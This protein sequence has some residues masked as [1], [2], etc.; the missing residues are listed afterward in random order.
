MILLAVLRLYVLYTTP[1][2]QQ[3]AVAPGWRGER[4]I[5]A[6]AALALT[7]AVVPLM[8]LSAR[9]SL[10][11]F[12]TDAD[13]PPYEVCS[14]IL[15]FLAWALT[16]T[17]LFWE[18]KRMAVKGAWLLRFA[19]LYVM[20]GQLAKLRFVLILQQDFQARAPTATF[21]PPSPFPSISIVRKFAWNA[22]GLFSHVLLGLLT[23]FFFPNLL[24]KS[25]LRQAYSP[26]PLSLLPLRPL[27]TSLLPVSSPFLHPQVLLGLLALLFFPNLLP[28][29]HPSPGLSSSSALAA[30]EAEAAPLLPPAAAA[31]AGAAGSGGGAGYV[32]L[33]AGPVGGAEGEAAEEE[34]DNQGQCSILIGPISPVSPF[35]LPPRSDVWV[36]DA[37]HG[38]GVPAPVGGQ[39]C[40]SAC[41]GR[42]RGAP[43]RGCC[44][45]CT[46]ALAAGEGRGCVGGMGGM[47][48]REGWEGETDWREER[49]GRYGR[50]GEKSVI[51]L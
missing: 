15:A 10:S 20:V 47:G 25:T 2:A 45:P 21:H 11:S 40:L 26:L 37:S 7:C 48:G 27:C 49:D 9:V 41:G 12:S 50:G 14:L 36:D 31:A 51:G 30:A 33:A 6:A 17:A 16:A 22:S 8:Q 3:R 29:E 34:G 1:R 28:Q 38:Y 42:R 46:P 23:L 13:L 5:V 35:P 32:P 43:S 39:R 24:L 44:V 4:G 19:V 18:R